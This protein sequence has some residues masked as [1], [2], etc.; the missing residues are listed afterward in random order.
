MIE[1]VKPDNTA[2]PAIL[3]QQTSGAS[4]QLIFDNG[5][6]YLRDGTLGLPLMGVLTG[7]L[8][9]GATSMLLRV[10][11]N[12]GSSYVPV[13]IGG[14]DTGGTGYRMLRVPN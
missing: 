12:A 4:V 5:A 6:G 8:S 11:N 13:L 1:W 14:P 7:A 10:N 3:S 9:S 2:G